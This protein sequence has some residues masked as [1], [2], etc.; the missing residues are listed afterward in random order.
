MKKISVAIA[1]Y[2][3]EENL[4]RCLAS[5]EDWTDELVIVDG[6][7]T[8]KTLEVAR[9]YGAKIIQTDNPAIFHINKQ[10]A[11]DACIG[12]WVLQLDTDEVVSSELR[13]EITQTISSKSSRNGY[14]IPRKNY[15]LNHWLR[16]GGQY[17]DYVIRLFRRGKG[18]FPCKSVHEQ[19]EIDGDVRH[20]RSPLLHYSYRT[21]AEYWKKSDAYTS[22]TAA[23]MIKDKIPK[24]ITSWIRYEWIYPTWKFLSLFIRHKGFADGIYGL[25][26]AFFTALHYPIA[27]KKY[28]NMK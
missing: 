13:R 25:L 10:K 1:A 22:L 18:K 28:V 20:L 19:I 15:L 7:S 6:G 12:E 26:F 16:K 24:T 21:L 17:P 3:E 9:R 8:D 27:Y 4:D 2:N 5:V 14:F 11:V 23:E